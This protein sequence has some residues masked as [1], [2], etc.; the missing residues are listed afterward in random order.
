MSVRAWLERRRF[1]RRLAAPKL[2]RA[3]A[4]AHPEAVFV[5]VGSNDG[6]QHDHLRPFV[7][8]RR[9]SG[10]MVEPVPYVF[11]RLRHNYEGIDRVRLENAAI[12]AADGTQPFYY[13]VDASPDERAGL[14]DWY[15]GVG[16]F[17]REKVLGHAKHIPDVERRLVCAEVP[18]LTFASLCRKHDLDRVDLVVIDTE[19][20]DWEIVRS[21]DLAAWRPELL[22]YE[23]F[24]LDPGDREACLAHVHAAGYRTMEEGFDT[25]CLAPGADAGVERVWRGLR[26]AVPG[27][28]VRDEA[29]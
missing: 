15:D 14:P 10:I 20:H 16:S 26:P 11:E 25:F 2:L 21:I 13:L 23:H 28:S 6:E 4:D 27:V 29:S 8:S 24:H 7:L 19:G 3:F 17:S 18:T 5:E 22:V 12:G 1:E 9:W